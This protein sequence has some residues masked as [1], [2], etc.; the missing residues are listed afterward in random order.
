MMIREVGSE[1]ELKLEHFAFS[2]S[3]LAEFEAKLRALNIRHSRSEIGEINLC[4]INLWDPD[5]NHIHVDFP[6][7]E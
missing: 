6:L 3:G 5:G 4:L 2:A 7:D 1:A